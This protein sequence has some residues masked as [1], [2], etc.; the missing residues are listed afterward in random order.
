[1]VYRNQQMAH[2]EHR[3]RLVVVAAAEPR[4][5]TVVAY[6]MAT[7]RRLVE[8]LAGLEMGSSEVLDKRMMPRW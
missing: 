4:K 8:Q 1:M 2:M 3:K 6:Y 7:H 5:S